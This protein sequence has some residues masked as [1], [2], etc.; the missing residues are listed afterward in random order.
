MGLH[1]NGWK[2]ASHI[3]VVKLGL[4][5]RI[6][7]V[8]IDFRRH[9]PVTIDGAVDKLDFEGAEALTITDCRQR[10]RMNRLT[11]D[12]RTDLALSPGPCRAER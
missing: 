2:M 5:R 7:E 10:L 8:A 9:I 1:V 12:V 4:G 11:R 3:R 6:E